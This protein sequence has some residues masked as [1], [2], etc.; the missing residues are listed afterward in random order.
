MFWFADILDKIVWSDEATFK[1]S[2]SVNRHNCVYWADENPHKVV[3]KQ[4]NQ[5]G[6]TVWGSISSCGVVGPVFFDRTV[7]GVNYLEALQRQVVPELQ[8]GPLDFGT[9][10]FQ[11]DGAPPH[12]ATIVREYL[13]STFP[14]RWIGR[15]GPI[16]WPP[17]SP[18][19]TPMD[20]FFWGSLK[21]AVYARNPKTVNDLK[22]FISEEF[23]NINLDLCRKVCRSVKKRLQLCIRSQGSHFEH[24]F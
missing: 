4:L 3:E 21:D 23:L 5:P 17:R 6:V 24:L 8:N 11:Q 1:L 10:L 7:T 2:G 14:E 16:E 22:T 20:F 13:N 19:L 9:L 12:Y 18:D 15:R